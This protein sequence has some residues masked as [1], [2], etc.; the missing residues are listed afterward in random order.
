MRGLPHTYRNVEEPAGTVVR[1]TITGDAGGTWH[2]ERQEKVWALL[3]EHSST[4]EAEIS[5]SPDIAWKVF[6]KGIPYETARENS[7]ITGNISLGAHAL[8]MVSVM[9]QAREYGNT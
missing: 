8:T 2:L 3:P 7:E 9:A 1:M 6:T 5:L 4:P